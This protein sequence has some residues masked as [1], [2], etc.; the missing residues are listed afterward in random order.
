MNLQDR[1][2]LVTGAAR[3]VGRAIALRLAGAGCP[4]AVHYHHSAQDA[5]RTVDDCRRAGVAAEA[6]QAD[7]GDADQ[8]AALVARVTQHFGGLDV[9][10]NNASLFES[11]TLDDFSLDDW[12]RTLD[13]NLTAPAVLVHAARE[14]LRQRRGRVVNLLDASL[15]RAWPDHLAYVVSKGGLETLTRVLARSL[16][17]DVNVVGVAP[18]VAA[19]PEDYDEET[20]DRLTRKIPLQRPGT[21]ED[22][23]AAVHFVLVDGDYITGT[24]LAID[25]GRHLA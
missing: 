14:Q 20:R 11:M 3:R 9:L 23:A 4:I 7:L 8:A 15:Q 17:P 22:I 6:F 16:A 24:V 12:R 21:P 2:V 18:G 5:A 10:I 13:V 1:V 19:W 25:G